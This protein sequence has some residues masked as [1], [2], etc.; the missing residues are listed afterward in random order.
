MNDNCNNPDIST[1]EL[2][3]CINESEV[4]LML[5]KQGGN[6]VSASASAEGWWSTHDAMTI[7]ASV[8]LFGGLIM[9]LVTALL[10]KG[11][12]AD[13]V[14]KIFGTIIIII[15]AAFLV[16]AGYTDQQISPV[17]GLL[18]T[19]AGY[20]LGSRDKDVEEKGSDDK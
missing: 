13:D 14:L 6:N 2:E 9:V 18:G 17:I 7:S 1:T 8:L 10:Y 16:V 19:I 4:G 15:F 11:K 3:K 5:Y 20:L 12:S